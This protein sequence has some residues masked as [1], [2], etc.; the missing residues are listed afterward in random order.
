MDG[1]YLIIL[2]FEILD[3]NNL[4]SYNAIPKIPIFVYHGT[5][6][7]VVPISYAHKIFDKWC[8]EG[9][10]SFEF[11]ESLTTGHILETFTGAAAA[12]TWLQNDLM[13]YL[14]IM[15]VSIQEDSL[16]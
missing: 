12:W 14:H 11:A 10:E 15:V 6:D 13:M 2:I 4:I 8:D 7:G 1:I 9:I 16:I 5:K 3:K